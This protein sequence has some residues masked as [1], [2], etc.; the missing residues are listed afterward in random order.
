[1]RAGVA[2]TPT[3]GAMALLVASGCRGGGPASSSATEAASPTTSPPVGD[4]VFADPQGSYTITIHS[5][6]DET[7]RMFVQEI[8]SWAIDARTDDFAPN[9][10]VLTQDSLG[11]DLDEYLAFSVENMGT[12][13]LINQ[14]TVVGANGNELGLLEYSGVVP[15][16][17]ADRPLHF[18]AAIDVRA[19]VAVVATLTTAPDEFDDYR[20]EIEPYLLT[21]QGT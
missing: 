20:D 9:V 16:G 4:E 13:D 21:L 2:S 3:I 19:G 18:L 5:D 17:A 15:G 12:L 1:M 6:W 14:T 7:P 11:A 10:N 8:E